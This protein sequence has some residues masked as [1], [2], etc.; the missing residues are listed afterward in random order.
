M[1]Q[2]ESSQTR[3][4]AGTARQETVFSLMGFGERSSG[5]TGIFVPELHIPELLLSRSG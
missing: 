5:F 1:G 4:T 2:T 3:R